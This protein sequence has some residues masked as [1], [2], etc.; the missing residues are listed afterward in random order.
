MLGRRLAKETRPR[1]RPLRRVEGA[2]MQCLSAGR[3]GRRICTTNGG[4]GKGRS[5]RRAF[6]ER[7]ERRDV[8][9][10]RVEGNDARLAVLSAEMEREHGAEGVSCR[11]AGLT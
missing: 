5:V 4:G 1:R 7:W 3:L 2:G 10:R 6:V 9:T 8:G 11:R